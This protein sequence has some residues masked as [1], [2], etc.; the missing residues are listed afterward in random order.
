MKQ[1]PASSAKKNAGRNSDLGLGDLE[2]ALEEA[3][4][5]AGGASAT[6]MGTSVIGGDVAGDDDLDTVMKEVEN[7]EKMLAEKRK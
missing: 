3:E 1:M 6:S 4:Q 5:S 7:A 2:K